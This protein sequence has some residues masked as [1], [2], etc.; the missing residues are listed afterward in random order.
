[1]RVMRSLDWFR[2]DSRAHTVSECGSSGGLILGIKGRE[3]T[4][5][6]QVSSFQFQSQ[7]VK[8]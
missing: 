1:M 8:Y 4:E 2:I 7:V 5:K 6:Y 3:G